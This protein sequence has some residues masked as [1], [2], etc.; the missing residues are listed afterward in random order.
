M[1]TVGDKLDVHG[2]I[3]Q[4]GHRQPRTMVVNSRHRVEQVRRRARSGS[5]AI[6]RLGGGGIRMAQ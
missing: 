1:Q 2:V 5:V 6:S 3:G 4:R